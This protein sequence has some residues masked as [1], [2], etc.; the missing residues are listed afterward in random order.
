MG[1]LSFSHTSKVSV[2]GIEKWR[3][4]SPDGA[5]WFVEWLLSAF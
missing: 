1:L 4:F 3:Q 5:Q 2:E